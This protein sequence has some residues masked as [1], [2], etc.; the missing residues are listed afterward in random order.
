MVVDVNVFERRYRQL[1]YVAHKRRP[2]IQDVSF[3]NGFW[4]EEEGYKRVF[5][6]DARE[7]MD[8]KSW[9]AHRDDINYLISKAAQPFGVLMS[10]SHRK[11]NLVSA[12]NYE[13]LYFKILG[14][15]SRTKKE[16]CDIIYNIYYGV[17]DKDTFDRLSHLL[18]KANMYDSLSV[19]SLYFF[20]KE[21][22]P[23]QDYQYVTARKEGTG[24]RLA[25]LNVNPSCVKICTWDKYQD[26][27]TVIG[28]LQS[29]L[30]PHHPEAT[31][32]DAQ[33]FLWMMW[34]VDN[35]TPEYNL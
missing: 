10:G 19:A 4:D 15:D 27:L 11:Q 35:T 32:L 33:S 29:L 28:E 14:G 17:D 18:A 5:W 1:L 7:A 3:V 25:R 23:D 30:K 9:P 20:L 6:E 31:L 21:K 16:A 12:P 26:Y 2:E 24:E 13:K 34:L 8:I 22:T